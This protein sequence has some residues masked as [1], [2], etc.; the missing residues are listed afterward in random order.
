MGQTALRPEGYRR[1]RGWALGSGR[2]W[3]G[4]GGGG[5]ID[6]RPSFVRID[7]MPPVDRL[8]RPLRDL[9]ISVTDRCNFRCALLH[10]AGGLRTRTTGSCRARRSCASRRSR[11]S[12]GSS[13]ASACEKLRLT[14]GEP[15]LRRDLDRAGRACSPPIDGRARLALTTNGSLLAEQRRGARATPGSTRVT[16]S[17]DS[18]DDATFQRDERRPLPGG[19][20]ARGHRRG[21]GRRARADQGQRRGAARRQRPRHRRRSPA[22]SRA[23]GTSLR[24]IEYMDV[25][26]TNGWQLD[27]VVAGAEI[28]AR[29]AAELPL[30]PIAPRLPRRGRAAAGATPTAAARSASSPRSPSRSAATAPARRLSAEGQLYTCLFAAAGTDLRA[31]LRDGRER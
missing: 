24:F 16:V 17:L 25:G 22:T 8:G 4:G 1:R 18:L 13:S 29:I 2:R 3:I 5:G 31:L 26:S 28:V 23:P 6:E 14:G 19:A 21:R 9:R 15:L 10:A 20:G 27:D 30:E 7:V 11:A 12:R